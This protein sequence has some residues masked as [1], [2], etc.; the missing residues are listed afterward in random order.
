[1]NSTKDISLKE[2]YSGMAAKKRCTVTESSLGGD[3]EIKKFLS[4][5]SKIWKT[6]LTIIPC[7][8]KLSLHTCLAMASHLKL[9]KMF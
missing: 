5:Q 7:A 3:E 8:G 9:P 4:K 1:M 6:Q 2:R